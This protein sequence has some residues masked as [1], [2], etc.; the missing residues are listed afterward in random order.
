V[1]T[2]QRQLFSYPS[3]CIHCTHCTVHIDTLNNATP[4]IEICNLQSRV[5]SKLP[6]LSH[7][8]AVTSLSQGHLAHN[9]ATLVAVG[10]V[11]LPP[12]VIVVAMV[13]RTGAVVGVQ[14]VAGVHPNLEVL[15]D[16]AHV[17]A[18]RSEEVIG[19][20]SSGRT[21]EKPGEVPLV[22]GHAVLL[23]PEVFLTVS[24][25]KYVT[26]G[27]VTDVFGF[28]EILVASG[29]EI[30]VAVIFVL[31]PSSIAVAFGV[32]DLEGGLPVG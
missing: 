6:F 24:S 17:L 9:S 28:S 4:P 29:T 7:I 16:Y 10:V 19:V 31:P 32:V 13:E 1:C 26:L 22:G 8:P 25:H 30:F 5:L 21:A 12:P 23:D 3:H 11:V 2:A 18:R 15:L 27:L 14:T 20:G